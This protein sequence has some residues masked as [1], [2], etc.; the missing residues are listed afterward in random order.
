MDRLRAMEVFV[1]VADAASFAKA[2][3]RLRISAPAATRAVA[4]IEDRLGVRLLQRTT[5]RV[6]LTEPGLRFLTS[7]RR[8]LGELDEA[9]RSA[10]GETAMPTG[11]LAIT[12]PVTFG[13]M[14]VAAVV[15]DFLRA[16]PRMTAS[17]W[18]FDRIVNLVEEGFDVA[19]RIG[20]LPDSSLV[21]RKVGEVRRVLVAS[22]AY[23]RR[24]GAP[25]RPDDLKRHDIVAFAPLSGREWRFGEG[26][27][28]VRAAPRLSVNDAAA[29]IALAMRGD[30]IVSALSYMVAPLVRARRLRLVLDDFAPPPVPVQIVYPQS[31]IVA[32]K[33]RAFID[34]AAPKLHA[35]A[36][37]AA[38]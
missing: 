13:R 29:A 9:E 37:A 19:V 20:S 27:T 38:I 36:A 22:P 30:G 23:L 10:A 1:A 28:G 21:V 3:A 16:Q 31:R 33:V 17:L 18:L 32:A 11:H 26:R 35:A 6:G 8:L 24:R 5:R 7:A 4:A 2:A 12:A 25:R 14:H 34:E 15:T